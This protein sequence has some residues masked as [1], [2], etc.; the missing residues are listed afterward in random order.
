MYKHNPIFNRTT[1]T[2]LAL[3]ICYGGLTQA[4][5]F[6]DPFVRE[7]SGLPESQLLKV[8]LIV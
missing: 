6:S 1:N 4:L 2:E 5:C 7:V 3:S 8:F